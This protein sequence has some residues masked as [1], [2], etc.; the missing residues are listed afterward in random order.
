MGSFTL[1]WLAI[2]TAVLKTL[3]KM[4]L[5]TGLILYTIE[6][7]ITKCCNIISS[8]KQQIPK[9]TMQ[10]TIVFSPL[11]VIALWFVASLLWNDDGISL[12]LKMRFY[13]IIFKV[14]LISMLQLFDLKKGFK[15]KAPAFKDLVMGPSNQ[16]RWCGWG[17]MVRL[18]NELCALLV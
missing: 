13:S 12:S 2:T 1:P 6:N 14:K 16:G 10:Q 11:T 3:V 8:L 9:L 15:F 7:M 5:K 17:V 18:C 4:D